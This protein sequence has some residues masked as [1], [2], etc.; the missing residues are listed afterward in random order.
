MQIHEKLTRNKCTYKTTSF[1]KQHVLSIT[2]ILTTLDQTRISAQNFFLFIHSSLFKVSELIKSMPRPTN[3]WGSFI[4]PKWLWVLMFYPVFALSNWRDLRALSWKLS[5]KSIRLWS[6][7]NTFW[8][9]SHLSEFHH[10]S[11]AL[12]WIDFVSCG[13]TCSGLFQRLHS[14]SWHST[15]TRK[16]KRGTE[17]QNPFIW[18]CLFLAVWNDVTG[19]NVW[20]I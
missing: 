11:T 4:F 20:L 3:P 18:H 15:E 10:S 5:S 1:M 2:Q 6:E 9:C 12:W 19:R 16:R 13:M 14:R 7:D 8:I 17:T